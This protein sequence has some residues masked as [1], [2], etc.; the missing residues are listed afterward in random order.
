MVVVV[1]VLVVVRS[2]VVESVVVVVSG[3]AVVVVGVVV[4]EVLAGGADV[5]AEPEL[6]SLQPTNETARST[7]TAMDFMSDEPNAPS[8]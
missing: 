7:R 6:S 1:V 2:A 5:A 4:A 8:D 3:D